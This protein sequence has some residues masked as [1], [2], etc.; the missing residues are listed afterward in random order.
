MS[1]TSIRVSE[2]TMRWIRRLKAAM[3]YKYSMTYTI[4]NAIWTAVST[5]DYIIATELGIINPRMNI[6]NYTE[7]VRKLF[8]EDDAGKHPRVPSKKVKRRKKS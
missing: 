3:E 5:T 2:D 8:K 4:D 6:K 7:K 1:D